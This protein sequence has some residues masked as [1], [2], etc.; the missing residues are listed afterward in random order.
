MKIQQAGVPESQM[1]G[2]DRLK[3]Q[4]G[5]RLRFIGL[6]RDR[7]NS[8]YKHNEIIRPLRDNHEHLGIAV[9]S[10]RT[11]QESLVWPEEVEL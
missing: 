6:Y 7:D 11:G 8:I 2:H 4:V 10:D 1:A 9:R 3:W 5:R